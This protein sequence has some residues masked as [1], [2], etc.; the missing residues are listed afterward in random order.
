MKAHGTWLLAA[1]MKAG[2]A[3]C[4]SRASKSAPKLERARKLDVWPQKAAM[5]TGATPFRFGR[6]R[7]APRA[8]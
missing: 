1:A 8:P 3:P 4:S 2:V 5:C 7:S 6:S